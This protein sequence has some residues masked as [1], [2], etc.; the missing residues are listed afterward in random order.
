[1]VVGSDGYQVAL[2]W[3]RLTPG[4]LS[5][6]RGTAGLLPSITFSISYA[7]AGH[8]LYGCA[9][10]RQRLHARPSAAAAGPRSG[11]PFAKPEARDCGRE[12]TRLRV[13]IQLSVLIQRE[14]SRVIVIHCARTLMY[15]A[16]YPD[17]RIRSGSKHL[18]EKSQLN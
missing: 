4:L 1:M 17:L 6:L 8:T 16:L 9:G 14:G 10:H 18:N 15:G 11:R 3:C 12:R 13:G 5:S 7:E 2:G